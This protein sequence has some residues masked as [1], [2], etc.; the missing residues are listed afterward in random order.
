MLLDLDEEIVDSFGERE[1]HFLGEQPLARLLHLV[2]H[3]ICIP[4]EIEVVVHGLPQLPISLKKVSQ[5]GQPIAD[6]CVCTVEHW[7][8]QCLRLLRAQMIQ[9]NLGKSRFE[10]LVHVASEG[11]V[12]DLLHSYLVL[13]TIITIVVQLLLLLALSV[14]PLLRLDNPA[15]ILIFL[16]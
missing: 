12:E 4:D 13:I 11:L 7:D 14:F 1:R 6:A 10:S 3:H 2:A 15:C 9:L 8:L 5:V 16:I